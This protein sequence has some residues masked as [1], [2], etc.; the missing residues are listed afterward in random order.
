[1]TAS[2][3]AIID[4]NL[5]GD[6]I[7]ARAAELKQC[8]PFIITID[9]LDLKSTIKDLE[10]RITRVKRKRRAFVLPARSIL[11]RSRPNSTAISLSMNRRGACAEYV[12]IPMNDY[13]A[14]KEFRD[15]GKDAAAHTRQ[16]ARAPHAAIIA[17]RA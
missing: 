8:E 17:A 12:S 5:K 6:L 9:Q 13:R 2:A 4:L 15:D 7:V 11:N 16:C 3:P 1:M 14:P 10:A